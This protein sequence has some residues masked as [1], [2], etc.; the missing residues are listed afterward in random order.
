[1]VCSFPE[2]GFTSLC[3]CSPVFR[4]TPQIFLVP[5]PTLGLHVRGGDD[6]GRGR[7]NRGLQSLPGAA[8][9]GVIGETPDQPDH[10]AVRMAPG[11]A[12]FRARR[13]MGL[14]GTVNRC[15]GR[16]RIPPDPT[17]ALTPSAGPFVCTISQFQGQLWGAG[18]R[19]W[20]RRLG[21]HTAWVWMPN[22]PLSPHWSEGFGLPPLS[23]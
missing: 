22:L 19:G 15:Q 18:D 11:T 3:C 4:G 1:M 10:S 5:G 16:E 13:L 7:R 23:C 12:R 21:R 20:E 6:H 14:V 2:H 9:G 8:R 17:W